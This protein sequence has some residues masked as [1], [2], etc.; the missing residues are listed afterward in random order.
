M[1]KTKKVM[2]LDGV[3]SPYMLFIV[4]PIFSLASQ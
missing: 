2:D 4:T 1:K 3:N